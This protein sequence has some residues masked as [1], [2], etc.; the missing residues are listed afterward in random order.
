MSEQGAT[1]AGADGTT[2]T[3]SYADLHRE[4]SEAGGNFLRAKNYP[5]GVDVTVVRVEVR[6]GYKGEGFDPYW[7]VTGSGIQGEAYVKENA[8]MSKKLED[9][10]IPDP[11]GRQFILTQVTIMGNV[12]WQIARAL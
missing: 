10:E 3:P 8:P 4:Q 12:T 7:V 5:N 6:P 11:T 1:N 9:L 2:N